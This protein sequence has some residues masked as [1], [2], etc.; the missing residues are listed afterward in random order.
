MRDQES[1]FRMSKPQRPFERFSAEE[2]GRMSRTE[3]RAIRRAQK[4][5]R[6][7]VQ[8]LIETHQ[9]QILGTLYRLL[10]PR[11]AEELEDFAQDLYLRIFRALARFDFDKRTRFSTWIY[12]F[13]K[14]YCFDVLKRRRLDVVSMSGPLGSDDDGAPLDL[15]ASVAPPGESLDRAE[16]AACVAHAVGQLPEEQRVVFVLREYEELNYPE[17]AEILGVSEGTVKSRLYRA[18]ETLRVRLAPYLREGATTG[19]EGWSDDS[20]G[21]AGTAPGRASGTA[22]R[23]ARP[24]GATDEAAHFAWS[25]REVL[26]S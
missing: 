26:A 11:Y 12:T 3:V 16:L 23:V 15:P 9:R 8:Y 1:R 6:G 5:D 7:A 10:G 21:G 20:A 4:G 22:P 2:R 13:T 25:L 17:I 24:A 19:L 14:N 18:K